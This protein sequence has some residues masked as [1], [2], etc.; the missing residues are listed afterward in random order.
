MKRSLMPLGA[1][2]A[3]ALAACGGSSNQTFTLAPGTYAVTTTAVTKDDCKLTSMPTPITI[4]VA[5]STVTIT[6]LGG[7]PSGTLQGN[8]A[9][10]A[11]V[12]NVDS[13]NPAVANPT[14]NCVEKISKT[15]ALSLTANDKFKAT[16][17]YHSEIFSGNACTQ[18][19]LGYTVPCDSTL[20]F[21][22]VKQ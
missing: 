5:G 15:I 2:A 19:N 10:L 11:S 7:T 13:N 4:T 6:D 16:Q 17:Q 22:A 18:A 8:D 1:V 9:S 20:E 3:F 21:E 12:Q 14:F